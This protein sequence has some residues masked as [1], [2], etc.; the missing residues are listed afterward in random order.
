MV[1]N[2]GGHHMACIIDGK[3]WDTWN[4]TEGCVGNYWIK[5]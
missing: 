1:I 2:I 4:S 3:V 5:K